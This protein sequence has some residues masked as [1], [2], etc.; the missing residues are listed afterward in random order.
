MIQLDTFLAKMGIPLVECKQKY[1][2]MS[3]DVKQRLRERVE[4]YAE[5]FGLTELTY[6]SFEKV[7]G[8]WRVAVRL[9]G[10]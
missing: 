4:E 5:E 9:V 2:H 6:G 10:T 7:R 1:S 3:F 8:G